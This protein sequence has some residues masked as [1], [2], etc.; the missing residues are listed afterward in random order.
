MTHSSRAELRRF[1]TL[2]YDDLRA[3][4]ARRLNSVELAGD[5]L[6]DT[7]M[8]LCRGADLPPVQRPRSYLLRM[9]KNIAL[10]KLSSEKYTVSLDDAKVAFDIADETP[11]PQRSLE[12][13][14]EL[15]AFQQAIRELTPRRRAILH[16]A[17]VEGKTLHA[18]AVQLEISQRLV[19]IELKHALAHCALRLD[20][21]LVQRFGPQPV[22]QSH[23]QGAGKRIDDRDDR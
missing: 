22:Q 19:E 9:A 13:K 18:I 5:A 23:G 21:Q 16:A 20:R 8:E 15:E 3:R 17:R 1:L 12:A 4:L 7:Y 2:C 10:R 6:Q 14:I 11:G